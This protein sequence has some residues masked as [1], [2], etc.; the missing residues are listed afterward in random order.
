[1]R[2]LAQTFFP[3]VFLSTSGRVCVAASSGG[4]EILRQRAS[5]ATALVPDPYRHPE[6]LLPLSMQAG[7]T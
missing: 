4:E 3:R 1:M 6:Q 2:Q 5:G 7:C